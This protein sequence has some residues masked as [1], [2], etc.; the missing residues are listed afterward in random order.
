MSSSVVGRQETSTIKPR[1]KFE[2]HTGW[3]EGVIHLPDGQRMMT[4]SRDGS[5]RVWNLKSGKQIGE[6]WR[7]GD[8]KVWTMALSPNGTK[9]VSGSDDGGVRL[10]DIDT[11]RLI[12]K[13]TGHTNT[14]ISVCWCQDDHRV[15]NGSEDGTAREWD[16]EKG[17][18]IVGPIKTGHNYVYAVVYSQASLSPKDTQIRCG[19]WLG[20]WTEQR[21]SPGQAISRLGYGIPKH[22]SNSLCLMG[23]PLNLEN[24]Q[25]ISPP[26]HHERI[27]TR[28]SMSFSADGKL[29]ATGCDDNNA[30]TWDVYAILT[31]AGLDDLLLDQPNKSL[32]VAD[33]TRRPVRQPIKVSPRIPRGFFDDTPHPSARLH[34]LSSPSHRSLRSR[35]LSLFRPTH[36]DTH[37]TPSR[38]RPFH[39]VRNRLS[40]R[41]SG[42]DIELHERPSAEVSV[43]YAKGKRRNAS[44]RERRKPIMKRPTASSSHPPNTTVAQQSS[45]TAQAQSSS[46]TQAQAAIPTSST[47]QEAINSSANPQATIK[48]AGRWIRFWLFIC[49]ASPEYTHGQH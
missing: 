37:D 17:K 42:A 7:D 2:G 22:R 16:V 28:V 45:G 11:G 44:A 38:P 35:L 29:L 32:L 20:P 15:V 9:V 48:H 30:Y 14:V 6:D 1:Q 19:A 43:P 27:V 40:A 25:P 34:S 10:W 31:E 36:A 4:C 26:L 12:A 46:Q 39:W 5:L 23:T 3:V 18:T 8:S 21:L 33:A 13:W 49:C 41:P 24:S 47:T